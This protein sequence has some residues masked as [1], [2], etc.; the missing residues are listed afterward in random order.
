[1][2]TDYKTRLTADTSQ[3]DKA[4]KR[5]ASQV[6]QYKK[7]TD[8]AK[9]TLGNLAKKF[10]PLAAQIGIAGGAFAAFDKALR[11]TEQGSDALDRTLYATKAS[12]NK[13][14]QSLTSGNFE[15]FIGGLSD[16]VSTAKEA[17][18]ALDDLGTMKMWKN[19]RIEQLKAQIAEDR[20]VVNN[21]N[22]SNS[23]R[24]A[25]QQ[26]ISLN[27][28]KIQALTGDIVEG[29]LKAAT[30]KLRE[31]AGTSKV[32]DAQLEKYL[33]MWE[34]GTLSQHYNEFMR[35]NSYQSAYTVGNTE[36]IPYTMYET[37]YYKETDRI[38]AN[39]M[40]SILTTNENELQQ[41]YDLLTQAAQLQQ[42]TAN[43]QNKANTLANKGNGNGNGTNKT[44]YEQGS[45][46]DIE[47]QIKALQDR[48]KN[49]VLKSNEAMVI[50]HQI[51]L[52]EK[53]KQAIEDSRKPVEKLGQA[54]EQMPTL[55][56]SIIDGDGIAA[57]L[58]KA[59]DAIQETGLTIEDLTNLEAVGDSFGYIGDMFSSL[60]ETVGDE[61]GKLFA[62]VGNSISAIG[63][64]IAKISALMMSEGAASVMDLPY[65]ANL[66]ALASVIAAVTGVIGS[67]SSI[68]SQQFADGGIFQGRNTI[69]DYGLAKVNAGEMILNG[70]QQARLFRMLNNPTINANVPN[71][72]DVEF[73]ISGSSL[74]GTINNYNRKTGRVR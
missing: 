31:I 60:S 22:T 8:Q 26:R 71:F 13:F 61:S 48:L 4:L 45:I 17:Y 28:E 62:A 70:T 53:K 32:S 27:M 7:Q 39:A 63:Q 64:A 36:G 9:A 40:K 56:A 6:Y 74:V 30:A 2:A 57:E 59:I 67:I 44:T 10:G 43:Q 73:V 21:A 19:S 5:S 68:A 65:P 38:L 11:S 47:A 16:I 14:F 3:H 35:K 24:A 18:N 33:K 42:T 52:L 1:M 15:S 49:E 50:Q 34:K 46:A 69:G 12:V 54:I 66:A 72:G 55:D 20:V 51:D 29:T 25:A 41:Y 58:Q 23:D 37:K